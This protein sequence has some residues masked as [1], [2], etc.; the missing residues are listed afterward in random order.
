MSA[1]THPPSTLGDFLAFLFCVGFIFSIPWLAALA[2][3]G[4]AS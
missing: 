3:M 2:R 1:P 4:V